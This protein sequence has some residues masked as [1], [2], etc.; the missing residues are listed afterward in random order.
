MRNNLDPD[1]ASSFAASQNRELQ[2]IRNDL[3]RISSLQEQLKASNQ[4]EHEHLRREAQNAIAQL[5]ADAEF[6]DRVR[7]II[8]FFKTA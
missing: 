1:D 8:R 3:T 4:A 2:G 7:E 5:S 6:L